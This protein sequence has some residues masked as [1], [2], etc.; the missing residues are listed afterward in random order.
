MLQN[1]TQPYMEPFPQLPGLLG[2]FPRF[3]AQKPELLT[4]SENWCWTGND[5]AVTTADGLEIVR[6]AG[7]AMSLSNRTGTENLQ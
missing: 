1:H 4:L 3:I 6:C 5:F 2:V 7:K